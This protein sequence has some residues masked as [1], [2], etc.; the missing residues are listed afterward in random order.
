MSEVSGASRSLWMEQ[1]SLPEYPPLGE[2][3][4]AD[5][6]VVGAGI[7]GMMTAYLL[8]LEGQRVIV[9]D[10]GP[11]G[12]GET[13]RTT[14]H[15]A[16]AMDDRFHVLEKLH[17]EDGARLAAESHGAAIDRLE[18]VCREEGIDA[19]FQRVDGW[20]FPGPDGDE[21]P[22]AK[23]LEAARRA[24]L[25]VEWAEPPFDPFRRGRALRFRNQARFHPLRFLAG[26]AA[27]I[28][29]QGGRIHCGNRVAEVEG[30]DR[31]T[32]RTAAGRVVTADAC[33]VATNSPVTDRFVTHVKQAPYRTF[34]IGA[35]VPAGSVPDALYW[36][37]G[38]PYL[39]I[40]LQPAAAGE[41][42]DVLIVG[43]EDHKTGQKDDGAERLER[44]AAWTREH[45]QGVE[46]VDWRWS[47]Q[48]FEPNDFLGLSGKHPG[49]QNVYMHSGDSGQGMTHGAIGGMLI[50]D[51]ILGR[52]NPWISLYDPLRVTLRS[53]GD[54][55]REN[56][57]VAA[58]YA[59]WALPGEVGS[60][61]DVLP[62]TGRVV[63]RGARLIAV[64]RDDEGTVH[65]RSATCTHLGCAIDWNDLEKSWDC[66]C[67][68]S[69]FDPYG[70]VMTGPAPAPLREVE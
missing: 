13:G 2:D 45:F 14:A 48:V 68:G 39:Y 44:L 24:G 28:E 4:T 7:A 31:V 6:C 17:G 51:Q 49:K 29:R 37:D 69:R 22:L 23:E 19:D 52:E 8:G 55:A 70:R 35:R 33:V 9:L 34:V 42:H 11:V 41:T 40:R 30:G 27:A 18:R 46:S 63:R 65:E 21:E 1:E 32:V 53:A 12:G 25:D 54:F 26:L 59:T 47:G 57:N 36:D 50:T 5:V 43:G 15:L 64:Y 66:P 61:E 3:A 38:D 56:L 10:D 60:A 58:Q 67:H 62:G 16:N 20:L